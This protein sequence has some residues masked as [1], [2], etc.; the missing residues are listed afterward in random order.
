MISRYRLR[1]SQFCKG[2][3]LLLV[4]S[5]KAPHHRLLRLDFTFKLQSW[6][7]V[8]LDIQ[9]KVKVKTMETK[10]AVGICCKDNMFL[11]ISSKKLQ[12][13]HLNYTITWSWPATSYEVDHATD[14]FLELL[15]KK[16]Y[17]LVIFILKATISAMGGC[18]WNCTKIF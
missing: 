14:V 8:K 4:I 7:K 12:K 16:N 13:E 2:E 3:S 9:A 5:M 11:F 10:V 17:C 15:L 1:R 18:V 6:L